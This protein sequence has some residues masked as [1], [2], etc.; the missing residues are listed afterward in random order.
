MTLTWKDSRVTFRNMKE[1][2]YLNTI[3][4]ED[5]TKIW[6]PRLLMYNTENMDE[7]KVCPIVTCIIGSRA[8]T[9]YIFFSQYDQKAVMTIIRNGSSS[10]SKLHAIHNNH[11]FRGADNRIKMSRVY[12]TRDFIYQTITMQ[13]YNVDLF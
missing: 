2:S 7:T 5:A 10:A 4:S 11:L 8:N 3:G 13:M 9:N 1:L 6:Y 12:T